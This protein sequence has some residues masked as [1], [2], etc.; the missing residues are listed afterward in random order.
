MAQGSAMSQIGFGF[1]VAIGF[2]LFSLLLI[3]IMAATGN[4]TR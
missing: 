2:F 4:L 3:I 1:R